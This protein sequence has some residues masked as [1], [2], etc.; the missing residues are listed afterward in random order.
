MIYLRVAW[1]R[2]RGSRI[3]GARGGF[4]SVQR[5]PLCILGAQAEIRKTRC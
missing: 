5:R 2:A 4:L 1:T 3:R